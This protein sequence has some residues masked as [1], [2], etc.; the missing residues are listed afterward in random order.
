[1]K[2]YIIDIETR[3]EVD[4]TKAGVVNY[5]THKST[6]VL[7]FCI[8]DIQK[9]NYYEWRRDETDGIN[10]AKVLQHVLFRGETI[11]IAHNTTFEKHI[12]FEILHKRYGFPRISDFHWF[13]T[14]AQAA[15]NG[16]PQGLGNL[17]L[18]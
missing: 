11:F 7:C 15:Y 2:N 16:L 17:S 12:W 6:D 10:K 3:S 5:A 13:C 14:M 9:R 4:L 18:A 8:F 1:M